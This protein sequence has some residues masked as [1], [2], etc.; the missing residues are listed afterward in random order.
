MDG[1]PCMILNTGYLIVTCISYCA[2]S[3]SV[4]GGFGCVV[5]L[6]WP[7]HTVMVYYHP[8]GTYI[9]YAASP[10]M[11]GLPCMTLAAGY[12]HRNLCLLSCKKR[13]K[14]GWLRM[15]GTIT[16]VQTHYNCNGLLLSIWYPYKACCITR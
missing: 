13:F 2:K 5:P 6:P 1:L 15:C 12:P 9:H 8:S 7:K 10:D 11:D 14:L 4:L 16:M 3:D